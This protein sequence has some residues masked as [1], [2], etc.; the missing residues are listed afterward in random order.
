MFFHVISKMANLTTQL[1]TAE[2][3]HM[4]YSIVCNV[5]NRTVF[6]HHNWWLNKKL[7]ESNVLLNYCS[8]DLISPFNFVWYIETPFV[9]LARLTLILNWRLHCSSKTQQLFI[10]PLGHSVTPVRSRD[11]LSTPWIV[12]LIPGGRY[13]P[14]WEPLPYTLTL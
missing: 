3:R 11:Y 4:H 5:T 13:R 8:C 7:F 14:L 6:I 12:Q 1:T 2:L 9:F 10:D